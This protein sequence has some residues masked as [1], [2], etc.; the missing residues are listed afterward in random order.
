[1]PWV[2]VSQRLCYS[3]MTWKEPEAI[4]YSREAFTLKP[5]YWCLNLYYSMNVDQ[6]SHETKEG[7]G[8]LKACTISSEW[9]VIFLE[10]EYGMC[11]ELDTMPWHF[12]LYSEILIHYA[13]R[14]LLFF[15]FFFF[16]L[17]NVLELPRPMLDQS[18]LHQEWRKKFSVHFTFVTNKGITMMSVNISCKVA[19]YSAM[20]FATVVI[21]WKVC[22]IRIPF[23]HPF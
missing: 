14:V 7:K 22:V 5:N 18:G 4:S 15:T 2:S 12:F 3:M 21:F 23:R 20:F 9:H 8:N 6:I 13:S 17:S 11:F 1:M 16:L 19:A 10:V